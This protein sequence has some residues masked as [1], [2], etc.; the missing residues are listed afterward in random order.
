MYFP[1]AG[2][3]DVIVI[4]SNILSPCIYLVLDN[5]RNVCILFL[6]R[7]IRLLG[8]EVNDF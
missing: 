6:K 2:N 3:Y 5:M 7:R 8:S 1:K 4:F